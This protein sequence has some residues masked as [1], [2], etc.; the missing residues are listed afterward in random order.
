M[1][2]QEQ[3]ETVIRLLANK[4]L[5]RD[6][7][8]FKVA[9]QWIANFPAQIAEGRKRV[10]I[11]TVCTAFDISE[12]E[13]YAAIAGLQLPARERLVQSSD[14]DLQRVLPKGGWLE[15]YS[16]YTRYTESPLSYHI[17]SSL[18]VLGASL[19]RRVWKPKGFFNIYPNYCVVLIGPPARVKKTSAV[20]I[21]RGLVHQSVLCPIFADKITPEAMVSALQETGHQF[22][23]APEFSVFFGK[24]KYN[25][26]LTTLMLRLLD[27]PDEFKAK[28]EGRGEEIV[29]NVILT[30]LGGSTMSLL[31]SATPDQVT[32][33]GFLSRFILVVE[34]DTD[35]CFP[36]PRKGDTIYEERIM[37]TLARLK[38]FSGAVHYTHEAAE[39]HD[40]WYRKHKQSLREINSDAQAEML[41]RMSE[42]LERTAMLIHLAEHDDMGV[43]TSCFKI[44]EQLMNYVMRK[45]PQTATA[46]TKAQKAQDSDFVLDALKRLGGAADHSRLLRRVSSRLDAMMFKKVIQTLTEQKI[47]REE[48]RGVVR[49]YILE[50]EEAQSAT[51]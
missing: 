26:T 51:E 11:E 1:N 4:R 33:S 35:R 18:C 7:P 45:T 19:G 16:E 50:G 41:G 8:P 22:V 17:F 46:I 47:V 37:Q 23:Y 6:S 14:A 13:I 27:S 39:W 3:V 25:E 29:H 32:S 10:L 42:H 30:V 9:L 44:A 21:A 36:E 20:D 49:F 38:H 5:G 34:S 40:A 2:E 24:Q 12:P 48:K 28:T 15:W 31:A 43:C